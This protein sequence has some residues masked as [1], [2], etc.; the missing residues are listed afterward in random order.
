MP[1]PPACGLPI[2]SDLPA[3]LQLLWLPLAPAPG[4]M[5]ELEVGLLLLQDLQVGQQRLVD[6][7]VMPL[8]PQQA[9]AQRLPLQLLQ[10][11][12]GLEGGRGKQGGGWGV[13]G[14]YTSPPCP[15]TCPL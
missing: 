13:G 11:G 6:T 9:E 5:L 7:P 15:P 2:V 1:G 12:P 4:A 3:P 8:P 10:Q 14:G